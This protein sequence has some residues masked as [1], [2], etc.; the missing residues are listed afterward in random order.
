MSEPTDL[1]IIEAAL[2]NALT[3]MRPWNMV[4]ENEIAECET[5]LAT[6]SRLVKA[7]PPVYDKDFGDDRICK[8]PTCKHPY[9]RHFDTYEDMRPVGCKYCDCLRFVE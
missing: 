9:Y 5:A 6:A 4:F 2:E 7:E 1:Q 8:R 3:A